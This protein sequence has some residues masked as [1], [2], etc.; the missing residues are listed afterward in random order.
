MADGA[1]AIAILL[2]EQAAIPVVAIR[3]GG[4]SPTLRS[5]RGAPFAE[6][7]G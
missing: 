3:R 7:S 6:R 4:L 5:S 1:T 2:D